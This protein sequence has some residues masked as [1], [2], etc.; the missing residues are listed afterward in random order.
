MRAE[1]YVRLPL[2]AEYIIATLPTLLIYA[3]NYL[4]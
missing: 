1:D 3:A 4:Y 2:N